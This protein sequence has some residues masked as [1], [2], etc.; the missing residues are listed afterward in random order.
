MIIT[1]CCLF[2][3]LF[4]FMENDKDFVFPAQKWLLGLSQAVG[5]L[6]GIPLL[7]FSTQ[8]I[9]IF[10]LEN[11]LAF[12]LLCYAAR[13]LSYSFIFN[14]FHVLP[15]EILTAVTGMVLI[16][17]PQFALKTAPK[18]LGTLVGLFGAVNVGL[19]NCKIV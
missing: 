15:I 1:V 8:L 19:G 17:M 10:G 14:P 6:I 3:Y 9:R 2:S 16:L 4:L 13:F 5:Y 18:H 7:F 11:L 12:G